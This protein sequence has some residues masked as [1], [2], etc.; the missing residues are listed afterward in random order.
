MNPNRRSMLARAI[1]LLTLT[2][3]NGQSHEEIRDARNALIGT[4]TQKSGGVLEARNASGRLAGTFNP[5]NRETRDHQSR[6]VSHG[7]TLAAL[8]MCSGQLGSAR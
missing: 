3:A 5:R 8:L 6:L 2:S 7:N 4:I 1:A